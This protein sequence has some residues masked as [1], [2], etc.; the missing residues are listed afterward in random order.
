MHKYKLFLIVVYIL[1]D[2]LLISASVDMVIGP[3]VYKDT[4]LFV[5]VTIATCVLTVANIVQY[6][7]LIKKQ[8]EFRYGIKQ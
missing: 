2:I 4:L 6:R 7:T 8:K 5:G 1:M 3:E